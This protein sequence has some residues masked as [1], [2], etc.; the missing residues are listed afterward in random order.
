[1][2]YNAAINKLG[3]DACCLAASVR[4]IWFV[5]K[6][7]FMDILAAVLIDFYGAA[8]ES[9]LISQL[10]AAVKQLEEEVEDM[11][12]RAVTNTNIKKSLGQQASKGWTG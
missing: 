8:S 12:A 5:L 2:Q 10:K 4:N 1:V 3:R 6:I 7:V 9:P 11:R